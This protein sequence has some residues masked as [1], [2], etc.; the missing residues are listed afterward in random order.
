M[1]RVVKIL[2]IGAALLM[3]AAAACVGGLFLISGGQPVRYVQ[4]TLLQISLSGR[5]ADLNRAMS[6]DSSPVRF[7]VNSGDNPRTIAQNLIN[8]ALINDGQL[9]I[10]YVQLND[11]DT[12]LEAGTYFL[13]RT[14]TIPE[15]AL[16]LT[17]SRNSYI[18]F[19]IIE[20]ERM[21]EIGKK[22]D[23]ARA[24]FGFS[25]AEFLA[26]VRAGA[27]IDGAF[28]N[29]MGIPAGASLEGFLYPD[30]YELPADVTPSMLRDILLQN[31][32]RKVSDQVV[33]DAAAQG[34]SMFE[35]VTLA[36]I[37]EREAVQVDEE[38]LIAGV[39]R[40][41]LNIDMRLEADPT[42]QYGI[43]FQGGSWWPQITQADYTNVQSNYNT[44]LVSGLPP[45]P[46]ASPSVTAIQAVV[47]PTASDYLF[48]RA[49]CRSDGYHSFAR[50]FEEH[51]ANCSS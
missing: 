37:V 22:I 32:S 51:L 3:I 14:Q 47:Y 10:D 30:S 28:A 13:K 40:N 41:R 33:S 46:I 34:W 35:V 1:N 16:A 2:I 48:F 50:T 23:D 49:D 38:P 19:R 24:Y 29:R 7:R 12:Q 44:Y 26:Q 36:S 15:I 8:S 25:G 11:I 20:G 42:V 9:F 43:G 4:K 17:D 39:Y 21:E 31:F 5:E 27:V 45:G 6:S 18:P